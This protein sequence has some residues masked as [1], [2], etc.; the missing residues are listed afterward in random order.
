MI[1]GMKRKV[2]NATLELVA[3]G[4][5]K[6]ANQERSIGWPFCFGLIYQPK[7][8]GMKQHSDEDEITAMEQK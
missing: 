6:V 3:R 2:V 8:P 4:A 1:S 5:D 7:H